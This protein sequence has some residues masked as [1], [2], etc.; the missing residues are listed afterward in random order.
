MKG[1]FR[2]IINNTHFVCNQ[3]SLH[4]ECRSYFKGEATAIVAVDDSEQVYGK[5]TINIPEVE[6]KDYEILVK[7]WAENERLA[8]A[9]LKTG[10]FEDTG[11]KVKT[12]FV[13]AQIWRINDEGE[14]CQ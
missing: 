3:R 13:E 2:D 12:G 8:A 6:L 14:A 7:T 4:L 5:L 11:L 9:V 10:L 1:V